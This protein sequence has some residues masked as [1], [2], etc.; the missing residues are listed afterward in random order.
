[1]HDV[2]VH[3]AIQVSRYHGDSP[4]L[5]DRPGNGC[6]LRE[7]LYAELRPISPELPRSG[8]GMAQTGRQAA[9]TV[10][11]KHHAGVMTQPALGDGNVSGILRQQ[12]GRRRSNPC[13][14]RDRCVLARSDPNEL[15]LVE[16]LV[17]FFQVMPED[18]A[19]LRKAK[20]RGFV[21]HA[22]P[23]ARD[24]M[25]E[26][27]AIVVRP[28]FQRVRRSGLA[29]CHCDLHTVAVIHGGR[30]RPVPGVGLIHLVRLDLSDFC[31]VA[32]IH[33]IHA[34]SQR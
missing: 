4:G 12:N 29:V 32:Q 22:R 28:N 18:L 27:N 31:A 1:M 24:Y 25:T 13:A 6:R 8:Y 11:L 5:A 15:P 34:D 2:A 3:Q 14:G 30:V 19:C 33:A 23:F 9:I 16:I 10:S 7:F 20:L 17:A 26:R 21:R